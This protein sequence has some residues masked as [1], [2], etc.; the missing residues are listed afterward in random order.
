MACP[1]DLQHHNDDDAP[2][3]ALKA[4]GG[5]PPNKNKPDKIQNRS[6]KLQHNAKNPPMAHGYI[7]QLISVL[8]NQLISV[9]MATN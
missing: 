5:D 6:A 9:L 4:P 3:P 8:M 2:V 1:T 7:N